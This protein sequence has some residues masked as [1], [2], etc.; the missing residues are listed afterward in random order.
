[1][2]LAFTGEGHVKAVRE[3][4]PSAQLRVVSPGFFAALGVPL[5][6]GRDFNDDDRR[7]GEPVVFLR[8]HCAHI[9]QRLNRADLFGPAI[10]GG[11]T[12]A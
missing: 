10:E 4:D 2:P 3:E 11:T 1:L 6:A 12:W 8:S 5:V 9:L 7:G